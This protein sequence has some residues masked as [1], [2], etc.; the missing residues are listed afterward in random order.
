MSNNQIPSGC[1]FRTDSSKIEFL[2]L[3]SGTTQGRLRNR[4]FDLT[5]K[6]V[7]FRYSFYDMFTIR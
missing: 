1:C 4:D 7:S 6:N 3:C 2:L 5:R